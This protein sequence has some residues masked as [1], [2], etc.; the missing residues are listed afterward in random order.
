MPEYCDFQSS[1]D[2]IGHI[3]QDMRNTLC[4]GTFLGLLENL[5][6]F[7]HHC[8][9]N[10]KL[11]GAIFSV[12]EIEGAIPLIHGPAGCAFHQ[13]LTPLRMYA[14]V[15]NVECTNFKENEV[16]Y[17]GEEK[18]REGIMQAYRKNHPSL[19][20]VLPTCVSALIGDDIS[21]ICQ[22]MRSRINCDIVHVNSEG[23]AHRR[24]TA[25]DGLINPIARSWIAYQSSA[26]LEHEIQGCGQ[27]EV[28]EALI[29]QLMEEQDVIDN[30]VNIE[31]S[32]GRRISFK[33]RIAEMRRIFA[34]IGIGI[35]TTLFSCNVDD[36]K[37]APAAS[38]NIITHNRLAAKR[39][40]E[41]FKTKAFRRSPR[42]S[43]IA[44][45]EQFYIDIASNFGLAGD[46]ESVMKHEKM[47]ALETLERQ[48]RF[49]KNYD[50]AIFS[51]DWLLNPHMVK[52]IVDD[53]GLNLKY[54][55]INTNQLRLM[56][57]PSPSDLEILQNELIHLF[58]D[59]DLN[60]QI[61]VNPGIEAARKIAED[62]DC[63]ISNGPMPVL[64]GQEAVSK[65]IDISSF[66]QLLLQT[67]FNGFIEFGWLLAMLVRRMPNAKPNNLIISKFDYDPVYY[68]LI[69]DDG[70]YT[71]R[72]MWHEWKAGCITR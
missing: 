55:C 37:R 7:R 50:F 44:G 71:S 70:C 47:L 16:I 32:G 5:N 53:F 59:W 13:R 69:D 20:V 67:S 41:R 42:H 18:L 11:S 36:I 1:N 19:I 52:A 56:N 8:G 30:C 35:N 68:P 33:R 60:A 72:D 4:E 46:A 39:M 28:S 64:H 45:I 15:H 51:R 21:G 27:E 61:M 6:L 17:G 25:N 58:S 29:N 10:C 62:I 22:D 63:M 26:S 3:T 34:K 12:S 48:K 23:F 65:I 24:R 38:L 54:F 31:L 14:P 40:T 43:G 57:V 49:F 66:N 2:S 9:I